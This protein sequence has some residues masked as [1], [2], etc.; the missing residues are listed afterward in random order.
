MCNKGSVSHL[1]G[2]LL[3]ADALGLLVL[4]RPLRQVGVVSQAVEERRHL[5]SSVHL[6][7]LVIKQ[8]EM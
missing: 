1:A 5:G 3:L 4:L 7:L 6:L 2:F 8:R